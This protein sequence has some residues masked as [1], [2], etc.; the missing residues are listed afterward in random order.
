MELGRLGVSCH[1]VQEILTD[2]TREV[3]VSR[4]E[5]FQT[6]R[7]VTVSRAAVK[8]FGGLGHMSCGESS[9]LKLTFWGEQILV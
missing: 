4:V 5:Y 8:M 7:E 3:T 9:C 1:R 6:A 2:N